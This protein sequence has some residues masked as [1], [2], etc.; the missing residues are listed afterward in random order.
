[1]FKGYNNSTC[2]FFMQFS[3]IGLVLV[4]VNTNIISKLICI[5]CLFQIIPDP[6]KKKQYFDR[7]IEL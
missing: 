6:I 4:N 5:I 1:M 7:L 2:N 3:C